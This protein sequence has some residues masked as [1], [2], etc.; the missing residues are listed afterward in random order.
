M[1][2]SLVFLVTETQKPRI[3]KTVST[4]SHALLGEEGL[5]NTCERGNNQVR[6]GGNGDGEY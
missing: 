1:R 5:H 3:D 6:G 4:R 2:L